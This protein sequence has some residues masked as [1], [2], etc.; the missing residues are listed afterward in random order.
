MM[1]NETIV[2]FGC[3]AFI[4]LAVTG[5]SDGLARV[6]GTVTF[7]GEP[8][9]R[10]MINLEPTDGKGSVTGSAIEDGKYR[11]DGVLPG[12]KIVR[13]SAVYVVSVQRDESDGSELEICD[14]LLPAEYGQDSNQ[15]LLVEAPNTTKD[16]VIEGPD[17]RKTKK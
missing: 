13:L 17:P 14:D 7:N 5:C 3:I 9:S 16:Y 10:G 2:R 12:E 1:N 8:V 11:I 4:A 6:E 15:R